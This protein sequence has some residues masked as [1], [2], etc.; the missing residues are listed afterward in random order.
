[1]EKIITA[2]DWL[3]LAAFGGGLVMTL[4]TTPLCKRLAVKLDF[5][6][7][8]ANN[9]KGH[10]KATPLLGGLAMFTAWLICIGI[11]LGFAEK[12]ELLQP[13]LDGLKS[14]FLPLLAIV[15][16][17]LLAVVLGLIDDKYALKAGT[18]FLGQFIVAA[19]AV[20][21][22]KIQ[23]GL[24]LSSPVLVWCISVFWIML[25]MNSINFFDNMDGLAVGTIAVAMGLFAVVA[26][27]HQQY[28]IAVFAALCCGVCCGFWVYNT[29]PA[30]IFMGDSG[31]HFLGYLAAITAAGVTFFSQDVSSTRLPVLMPLFI[32]A[33]PLFDTAM[34]VLIRTWNKKPFWIGD[35]NHIS[36]RFVKMGMSRKRAVMLVHLLALTIGIGVLP[37]LWGSFATA[38][39]IVAQ[40]ILILLV[41]TALQFFAEKKD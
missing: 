41:V 6:D 35:H 13:Y 28:F 23:I 7:R 36:H 31:S 22:G 24:F 16:G 26:G 29:T 38:V 8:P 2:W 5:M 27:L 33:L 18:K 11:G 10:A 25:L 9:H 40:T 12:L 14:V 3:Y 21:F 32:L 19:I 17:A 39:I 20:T 34:V 37:I 1:M 30:S 15:G 4:V